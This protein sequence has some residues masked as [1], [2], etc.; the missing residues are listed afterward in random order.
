ME[1]WVE[2]V[3]ELTDAL[4]VLWALNGSASFMVNLS[5]A[6]TEFNCEDGG[7]AEGKFNEV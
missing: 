1:R 6:L 3:L 4:R 2:D 5:A 7:R